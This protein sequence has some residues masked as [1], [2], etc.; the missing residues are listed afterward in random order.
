MAQPM[1]T[2]ATM[3]Q[4]S[5]LLNVIVLVPVCAGLMM[6]AAWTQKEYGP[7]TAARGILLSVYLA[8]GA[9]S[10][11]LLLRP[12]TAMTVAL[13]GV[14][15]LYKFTTPLTVK[16]LKNPVVISNLAIATFHCVTVGLNWQ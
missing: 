7:A 13:L 4:L 5:L 11:L 9:M 6:N 1:A 16:T 10:T 8:I 3:V 12:H 15:I 14:Q 2:M